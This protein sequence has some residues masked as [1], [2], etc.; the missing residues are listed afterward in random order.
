[1]DYY[2]RYRKTLKMRFT[3][4]YID[5]D[6]P[7]V[8]LISCDLFDTDDRIIR[9]DLYFISNR[10]FPVNARIDIHIF[11]GLRYFDKWVYNYLGKTL[12]TFILLNEKLTT[13]FVTPDI[14]IHDRRSK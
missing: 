8:Y 11:E 2:L 7:E 12:S 14:F 13:Q 9:D 5:E 6:I 3:D 4:S 10:A 1:M